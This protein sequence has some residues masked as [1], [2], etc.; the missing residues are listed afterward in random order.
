MNDPRAFS[1]RT[2]PVPHTAEPIP[3]PIVTPA[4]GEHLQGPASID[5]HAE[6]HDEQLVIGAQDNSPAC[7]AHVGRGLFRDQAC[8]YLRFLEI[9]HADRA[10]VH[11]VL[12][13]AE[14]DLHRQHVRQM[15]VGAPGYNYGPPFT[16]D[17]SMALLLLLQRG[18]RIAYGNVSYR[19]EDP[20][21]CPRTTAPDLNIEAAPE[22]GNGEYPN[23]RVRLLRA[24]RPV[25]EAWCYSAWHYGPSQYPQQLC[26]IGDIG[27]APEEQGQGLGRYLLGETVAELIKLGY[28]QIGLGT[29]V[30]NVR[31]RILYTSMG[32]RQGPTEHILMKDLSKSDTHGVSEVP[33][34][35]YP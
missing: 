25:G 27:I 29:G 1:L 10:S 14:S 19:L 32:F 3:A 9:G 16:A 5:P 23:C 35:R 31:A 15:R 6:L 21:N 30:G 22:S 7:F 11:A 33:I 34:Y 2:Q 8:G 20:S 12:E 13:R 4:D 24:G 28:T 18:Y 26:L 17:G